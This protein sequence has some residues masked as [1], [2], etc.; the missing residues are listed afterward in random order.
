MTIFEEA[1]DFVLWLDEEIAKRTAH[2]LEIKEMRLEPCADC[3]GKG[4]KEE[5]L[6]KP[7]PHKEQ[8]TCATCKGNKKVVIHPRMPY[9]HYVSREE[10]FA[11]EIARVY[12]LDPFRD[13]ENEEAAPL[14]SDLNE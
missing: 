12:Q 4:F 11:R 3:G 10:R 7:V 9:H 14:A 13:L 8:V 1:R 2:S 6:R 5:F